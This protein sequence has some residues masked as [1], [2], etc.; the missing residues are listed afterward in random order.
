MSI[1]NLAEMD[2]NTLQLSESAN[3]FRPEA[4]NINGTNNKI[5]RIKEILRKM[6]KIIVQSN[7][8]IS[9]KHRYREYKATRTYEHLLAPEVSKFHIDAAE[10]DTD[11][12]SMPYNVVGREMPDLTV[13][14]FNEEYEEIL[15][16]IENEMPTL[17]INDSSDYSDDQ[18][19]QQAKTSKLIILI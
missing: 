6:Q 17:I 18:S 1:N 9:Q 5:I 16:Y 13:N 10:K 2:F 4:E 8:Q 14:E 15:L 12:F 19:N 3:N 11:Y 7:I